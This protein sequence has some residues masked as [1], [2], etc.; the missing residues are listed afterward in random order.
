MK[1]GK[2]SALI[3]RNHVWHVAYLQF[4]LLTPICLPPY[5]FAQMCRAILPGHL[6]QS[7]FNFIFLQGFFAINTP[8]SPLGVAN[9][10]GQVAAYVFNF[11]QCFAL[12]MEAA[13][14]TKP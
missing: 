13:S 12:K 1:E 2:C 4:V 11:H 10:S 8:N 9:A 6:F 5:T 3:L 7:V 14:L